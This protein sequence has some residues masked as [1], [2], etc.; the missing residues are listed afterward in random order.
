MGGGGD[1]GEGEE[2]HTVGV[3][4]SGKGMGPRLAVSCDS[5]RDGW[6]CPNCFIGIY[7]YII[8]IYI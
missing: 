2:K 5:R 4:E 3:N 1:G 7:I 8:Y 6:H